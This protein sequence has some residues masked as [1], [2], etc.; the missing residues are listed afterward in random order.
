MYTFVTGYVTNGVQMFSFLYR[1]FYDRTLFAS[2]VKNGRGYGLKL[3]FVLT[4]FVALCLSV[5]IFFVFSVITPQMISRLAAQ[6][7]EVVITQGKIVSPEGYKYSYIFADQKTFFVFD[8]TREPP[9]LKDLPESGIYITSDAMLFV[10]KGKIRRFP[11]VQLLNG[12]DLIL[13]QVGIQQQSRQ[14]IPLFRFVVPL[15]LF[16]FC[17]PGQFSLYFLLSVFYAAV[18]YFMTYFLAK[19]L[20]WD[21][22]MRL[23]ALSIMPA[24]VLNTVAILLNLNI[25]FLLGRFGALITFIY[26][27]CFLKDDDAAFAR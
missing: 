14:L 26:M 7:P 15:L 1:V 3:L 25:M 27:F 2:F 6:L 16:L 13:D 24:Y 23:A 5:K 19:N 11:F 20:S 21:Q 22:R 12:K 8:T 18:S 4:L 9:G 10:N 17:I